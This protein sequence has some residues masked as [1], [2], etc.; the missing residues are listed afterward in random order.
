[1][2]NTTETLRIS[3]TVNGQPDPNVTL[4][5]VENGQ[6]VVISNDRSRIT[7]DVIVTKL[8]IEIED[9]RVNDDGVYRVKAANEIGGDFADFTIR[10]LG[11]SC[12]C[13]LS[14]CTCSYPARMQ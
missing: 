11:E 3:G 8:M 10:T 9:I 6:E 7:V 4:Y 14:I 2:I 5:K 13:T 12:T 1:M